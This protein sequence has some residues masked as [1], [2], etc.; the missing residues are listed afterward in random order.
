MATRNGVF[1]SYSHKDRKY[2]ER[3][4]VHLKPFVRSGQ[5]EIWDDT[6]IQVG[7]NWSE[8]IRRAL[9]SAKVAILLISADYLASD[10][11][12]LDEL[13]PHNTLEVIKFY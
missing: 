11:I 13:P 8:A 7:M 1:I 9:A 6:K 10:F 4:Q 12:A 5:V 3:L 2:V